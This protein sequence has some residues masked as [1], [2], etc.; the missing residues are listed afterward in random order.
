MK[1]VLNFIAHNERL[2]WMLGIFGNFSFF[3]GSILFLSDEWETVGVWLFILGSGG[4]LISSL[5][6]FAAWRGRQ[7]D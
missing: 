7:P 3:L 1:S 4:M 5:G 6:K 2:H